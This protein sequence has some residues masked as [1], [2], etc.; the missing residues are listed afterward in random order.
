MK[1]YAPCS[2]IRADIRI[3][4][5]GYRIA[6]KG[7]GTRVLPSGQ[8]LNCNNQDT[9][10]KQMPRAKLQEK[11]LLPGLSC[12]FLKI[13]CDLDLV[14]WNLLMSVACLAEDFY[15]KENGKFKISSFC[16]LIETTR[17]G[18]MINNMVLSREIE[19]IGYEHKRNMLQVEFIVGSIYQ[20]ENVPEMVYQEFLTAPSYGRFFESNIKNKYRVRKVR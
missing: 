18:T 17:G 9:R 5:R 14:I 13:V 1:R 2:K 19:W 10:T 3:L 8:I 11:K 4:K 7:K 6:F 12:W 20:Y 15:K 16:P